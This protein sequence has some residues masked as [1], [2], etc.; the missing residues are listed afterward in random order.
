[1]VKTVNR[2]DYPDLEW[3]RTDCWISQNIYF[4]GWQANEYIP[5]GIEVR[6]V[7]QKKGEGIFI[8]Q[9]FDHTT[10]LSPIGFFKIMA[11]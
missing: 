7:I 2:F 10:Y 11:R 1:V 3:K 5:K 8:G 4:Q 6:R 9:N